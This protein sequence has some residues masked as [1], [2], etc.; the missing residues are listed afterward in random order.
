[1]PGARTGDL[2]RRVAH[3]RRELELSREQV[4]RRAGIDAG[5]LE[6]LE[7]APAVSLSP[8]MLVHLAAALETSPAALRGGTVERPP[9]PGRAGPYPCLETL[10][11][12]ECLALLAGG[13]VGRLVF[14][15]KRG[16]VALPV[17]F[18]LL[19]GD[20]VFRTRTGGRLAAVAGSTASFEVDRIDEAM[21]EGWSVLVT[22]HARLV[23]DAAELERIG[24]L[25]IEPWPGGRREAVIRIERETLTGRRIRQ[26]FAG[27]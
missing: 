2:A 27:T 14:V 16:P 5:Y 9:G 19:E 18:R 15:S 20:V 23:E 21:S 1:M 4:A 6:Y 10:D 26:R 11:G 17:N 13:G 22:G 12:E 7:Q 8:G 25:G 24:R 3:R